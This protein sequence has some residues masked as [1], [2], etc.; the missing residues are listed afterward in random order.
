MAEKKSGDLV[1]EL[2]AVKEHPGKTMIDRGI[3]CEC[4]AAVP[5]ADAFWVFG[6]EWEEPLPEGFIVADLTE[7]R[8]TPYFSKGM[9]VA[10]MTETYSKLREDMRKP[11]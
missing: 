11:G 2:N 7:Q 3:R 1:C 9:F 5:F 8:K 4:L 6:A 10:G